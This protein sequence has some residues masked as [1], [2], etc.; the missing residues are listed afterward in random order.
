MTYAWKSKST[1]YAVAI[2]RNV[3]AS[4]PEY[5]GF[6]FALY[7]ERIV[8]SLKDYKGAKREKLSNYKDQREKG[9]FAFEQ[10][11]LE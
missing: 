11:A 3:N 1:H 8:L 6:R 10:V 9:T 7:S 2:T 4:S 5:P